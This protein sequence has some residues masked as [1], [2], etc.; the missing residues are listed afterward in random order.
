MRTYLLL[1]TFF[2][3]SCSQPFMNGDFT[4]GKANEIA[5]SVRLTP[6]NPEDEENLQNKALKNKPNA[7]QNN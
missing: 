2:L 6:D 3:S 1:L 4:F 7:K 5:E